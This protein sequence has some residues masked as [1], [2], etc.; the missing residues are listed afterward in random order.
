MRATVSIYEDPSMS[1]ADVWSDDESKARLYLVLVASVA[2]STLGYAAYQLSGWAKSERGL[3]DLMSL[4]KLL[5]YV[6]VSD[7][8]RLSMH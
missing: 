1:V 5:R 8:S 4:F 3:G 7:N 6:I 2:A